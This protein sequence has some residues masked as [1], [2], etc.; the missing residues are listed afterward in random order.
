MSDYDTD[1]LE[2]SE[3]QSALLRRLAAGEN[4]NDQ[5]DW[6][7]IIDEV[8]TVGRSERAALRSHIAVV[9][10]LLMKLEASPSADPREGWIVT[11]IRARRDIERSLEDSPSL[12]PVVPGIYAIGDT[13]ACLGWRDAPVPGLAPA[14]KQQG[15][16]VQG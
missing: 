6:P 4:I 2:W 12:R 1:I 9:L 10:E 16:Y 3:R 11:V 5:I 14:A 7:N 13:A 15:Q 8:E